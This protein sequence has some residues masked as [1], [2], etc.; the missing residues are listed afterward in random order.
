MYDDDD[1]NQKER[2]IIANKV[3]TPQDVLRVIWK[4]NQTMLMMWSL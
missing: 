3:L 1:D 4:I 2:M